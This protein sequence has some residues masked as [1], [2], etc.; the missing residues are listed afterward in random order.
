MCDQFVCERQSGC[1]WS[2]ARRKSYYTWISGVPSRPEYLTPDLR[3]GTEAQDTGWLTRC[4]TSPDDRRVSGVRGT[5]LDPTD[6][7][8]TE[9]LHDRSDRDA[10]GAQWRCG[11]HCEP[12][13]ISCAGIERVGS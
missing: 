5:R 2:Q 4:S 6:H 7:R 11:G 3:N 10:V 8:R 1:F 9:S 13:G 12:L